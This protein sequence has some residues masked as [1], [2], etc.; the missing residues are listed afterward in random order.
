MYHVEPSDTPRWAETT[1]V[2]WI[3]AIDFEYDFRPLTFICLFT[4]FISHRE[5]GG[6]RPTSH[7]WEWDILGYIFDANF[8]LLIMISLDCC[9]VKIHLKKSHSSS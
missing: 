8:L 7:Y 4:Y 6:T 5:S 3:S 2:T 9:Y 1:C